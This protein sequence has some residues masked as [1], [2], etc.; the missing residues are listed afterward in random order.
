MESTIREILMSNNNY[1]FFKTYYTVMTDKQKR[2]LYQEYTMNFVNDF[3]D[4][5]LMS[6]ND[7]FNQEDFF[8]MVKMRCLHCKTKLNVSF[9]YYKSAIVKK[10][11]PFPVDICPKCNKQ[12]FVPEDIYN[13]LMNNIIK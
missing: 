5:I 2:S 7:F 12:Y 1:R 6:Y 3:N 13:T 10:V 11:I 8:E 4:G 9:F